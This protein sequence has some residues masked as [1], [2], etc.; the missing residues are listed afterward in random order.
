[1]EMKLCLHRVVGHQDT[2]T[3]ILAQSESSGGPFFYWFVKPGDV[4]RSKSDTV[5]NWE[6][7]DETEAY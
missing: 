1:M 4:G 3:G 2:L 7:T 6:G 5:N